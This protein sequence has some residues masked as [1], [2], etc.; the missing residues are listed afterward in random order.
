MNLAN[1]NGA[2]IPANLPGSTLVIG[3]K[4][5]DGRTIP[6][7]RYRAICTGLVDDLG[8]APTNAEWIQI[9]RAAALTV[10]A[11][12]MEADMVN[13]EEYD[14]RLHLAITKTLSAALASIGLRGRDGSSAQIIDH[15]ADAVMNN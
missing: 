10:Q 9:Q 2:D 8:H 1:G 6:A 12:L 4:A 7:R 13:G 11:E 14:A 3:G 5:V 15:F